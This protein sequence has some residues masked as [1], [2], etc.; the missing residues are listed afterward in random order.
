MIAWENFTHVF[1]VKI[2]D[3]TSP[4]CI[5][6][7][8]TL[9]RV[10]NSW[11]YFT[12]SSVQERSALW[13][14][15]DSSWDISI[16][17]RSWHRTAASCIHFQSSG[18]YPSWAAALWTR[19]ITHT[20]CAAHSQSDSTEAGGGGEDGP[21]YETGSF[22]GK[23]SCGLMVSG[24]LLAAGCAE[25]L[26]KWSEDGVMCEMKWGWR[27][28]TSSRFWWKVGK[29][30]VMVEAIADDRFFRNTSNLDVREGGMWRT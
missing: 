9:S 22:Q 2:I 16:S 19:T 15:G 21:G 26:V 13:R 17:Y 8:H 12:G 28:V 29:C 24:M 14:K 30:E 3:V 4:F 6:L 20:L 5:C 11:R 18:P 10:C 23:C 7:M 25:M 1:S 27:N